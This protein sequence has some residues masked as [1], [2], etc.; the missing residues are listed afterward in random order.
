MFLYFTLL[1]N[2]ITKPKYYTIYFDQAFV[3]TNLSS[4]ASQPGS[5]SHQS[6][7]SHQGNL[8]SSSGSQASNQGL[9]TTQICPHCAANNRQDVQVCHQCGHHLNQTP[10]TMTDQS[11][12]VHS[13]PN[14][15]PKINAAINC[16][17]CNQINHNTNYCLNCGHSLSGKGN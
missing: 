9:A 2:F 5:L 8:S 6:Y 17:E 11:I 3:P 13:S 16:P 14:Q 4:S 12:S 15:A 1:I 10:S 7:M